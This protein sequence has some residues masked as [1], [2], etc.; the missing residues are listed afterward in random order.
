MH[1]LFWEY[2][3][4]DAPWLSVLGWWDFEFEFEWR[5]DPDWLWNSLRSSDSFPTFPSPPEAA[6]SPWSEGFEPKPSPLDMSWLGQKLSITYEVG[7]AL[8]LPGSKRWEWQIMPSPRYGSP[9]QFCQITGPLIRFLSPEK[10][11]GQMR[12]SSGNT[13]R[14]DREAERLRTAYIGDVTP[15]EGVWHCLA[16]NPHRREGGNDDRFLKRCL[17]WRADTSLADGDGQN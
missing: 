9:F 8:S 15:S 12:L 6:E 2:P 14:S 7:P 3:A 4:V 11:R 10:T 5:S 1:H 17:L 13:T 16:S